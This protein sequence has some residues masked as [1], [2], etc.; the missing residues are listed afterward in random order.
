M[1]LIKILTHDSFRELFLRQTPGGTGWWGDN[2]FT[3][4]DVERADYVLVINHVVRDLTIECPRDNIWCLVTEPP[5]QMFDWY[6]TDFDKF[7]RVF[8]TDPD[9]KGN[10]YVKSQTAIPWEVDKDYD[11]LKTVSVPEKPKSLSWI[12]SN[13]STFAGHKL[14]M[15]F[16]DLLRDEVEMDLW[17]HG[18]Q[19]IE[20]KWD[21]ISPYRYSLAIEN[22]QG[23]Y[24]WSEKLADCYLSF[25]MPI[26]YGCTRIDDYFPS[27]SY[28]GIDINKPAEAIEII[29]DAVKSDLWRKNQDAIIHARELV[30]EKYQLM[31]FLG[32]HIKAHES[33]N[34]AADSN[35]N[36]LRMLDKK[37]ARQALPTYLSNKIR[38]T[39]R[40]MWRGN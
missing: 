1:S 29:K 15:A 12:T 9:L 32:E 7:G 17:G 28:I 27:E 19:F 2:Q 6:R 8:T 38:R 16:L 22:Y 13:K 3:F 37:R 26:Y 39:V 21:G 34:P 25:T 10:R 4:D 40:T 11:F 14:R 20:D 24:Y 5:E 30:L 23:P 31:P 33:A 18:F 36:H 35:I